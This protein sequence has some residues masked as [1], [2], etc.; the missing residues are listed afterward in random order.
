M[1]KI[2]HTTC[3]WSPWR[4]LLRWIRSEKGMPRFIYDPGINNADYLSKAQQFRCESCGELIH[5][6]TDWRD[7][8]GGFI[9]K[10]IEE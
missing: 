10:C 5:F 3:Y 1:A 9:G 2:Y 6:D 8:D 4:R 7:K